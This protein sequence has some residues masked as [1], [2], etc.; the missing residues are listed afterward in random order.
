MV[1]TG[2]KRMFAL[3]GLGFAVAKTSVLG[4]VTPNFGLC[5]SDLSGIRLRKEKKQPISEK[6]NN[7]GKLLSLC[8]KNMPKENKFGE[9]H[10]PAKL[11]L[12]FFKEP[13]NSGCGS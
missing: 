3:T 7:S 5:V 1:D 12:D 2:G 13:K 6:K 11:M 4:S 10:T 8:F 9:V